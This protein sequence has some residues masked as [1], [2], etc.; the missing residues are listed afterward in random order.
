MFVLVKCNL[1]S[2]LLSAALL[3]RNEGLLFQEL[4]E[5]ERKDEIGSVDVP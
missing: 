2:V 4:E 3:I 5:L 1:H